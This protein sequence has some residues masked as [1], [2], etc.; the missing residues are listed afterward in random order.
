MDYSGF[1]F[2]TG[3]LVTRTSRL[4]MV[5]ALL[6]PLAAVL[7]SQQPVL[8]A[9]SATPLSVPLPNVAHEAWQNRGR[10]V[11][12]EG[13]DDPPF[14]DRDA[15]MGMGWRAVY[16]SVSGIDGGQ[17]EVSGAFFIPPGIPPEAGWPVISFAHGTSGIGHN[18]GPAQQPDLRGYGP[19]VQSL[20]ANNYA[21][22][23]SDYEGLGQHGSHPYLEPRTAA[24]NTIDA[25]RAMGNIS[26][27]VS[28]Q[29]VAAGYSQGGQAVWAANELDSFYG[30]G[31]RLVGTVALAPG[32][33]VTGVVDLARSRSLTDEQRALF[34]LLIAGLARYSPGLD[35]RALLHG[36]AAAATESLR[37]CE[38][39]VN[40]DVQTVNRDVQ[41][42]GS[43]PYMTAVRRLAEANNLRPATLDDAA[44]L[45]DALRRVALPQ[46][47]LGKPMLVVT[48]L[49]D[50]LVLP[51]WV[52]SAV[53]QSCALG[54]RIEHLEVPEADH[55]SIMW[56]RSEV[57]MQWIAER[58]AGLVASSNCPAG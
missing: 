33:N 19:I 5:V 56:K 12:L 48:G 34:P 52:A 26:S 55:Q 31:L 3:Q 10:I 18:C 39:P 13:Y 50:Q 15:V 29:W 47:P 21:V 41:T 27:S 14:E 6:L 22:A 40:Q 28:R 4:A 38:L 23:L 49:R 58:F 43:V 51:G 37:R 42:A 35:Q 11:R 2:S 57:V 30:D 46:R 44:R 24:F 8:S 32:A 1:G 16:G 9:A 53:R 25:V 54:G 36:P 17:R 45:R 7:D 20:L